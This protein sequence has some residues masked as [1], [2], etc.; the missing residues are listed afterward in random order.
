[1]ITRVARQVLLLFGAGLLAATTAQSAVAAGW[2]VQPEARP[3]PGVPAGHGSAWLNGLAATF[4]FLNRSATHVVSISDVPTPDTSPPGCISRHSSN[5][6][7][8]NTKLTAATRLP[9]VKIE[10]HELAQR[11]HVDWID[12][13]SWF[14]TPTT[15]PA[16]VGNLLVYRNIAHIEPAWSRFISRVLADAIVPIM[17]GA[18]TG[19]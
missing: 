5:V 3:L 17:R 4:N 11:E 10:E 13:T 19:T 6:Q 15:C 2:A 8:C 7:Q 18:R 1:M 12:P 16:I 9:N 14:C